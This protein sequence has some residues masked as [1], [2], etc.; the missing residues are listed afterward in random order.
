MVFVCFRKDCKAC[1]RASMS[2]ASAPPSG[3]AAVPASAPCGAA[4]PAK[5]PGPRPRFAARPNRLPGL[6]KSSTPDALDPPVCRTFAPWDP[7]R[8]TS[9]W[10]LPDAERAPYLDAVGFV[11]RLAPPTGGKSAPDI[12]TGLC[13]RRLNAERL[14]AA[15]GP[16]P[17]TTP[18]SGGPAE[19]PRPRRC[20]PGDGVRSLL[21][22]PGEEVRRGWRPPA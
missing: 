2:Q 17:V 6:W 20:C 9:A 18:L 12:E 5:L 4:A 22:V 15:A 7:L 10:S 8:R 16:E 3:A 1:S 14:L 21:R 13:S 11:P 19:S